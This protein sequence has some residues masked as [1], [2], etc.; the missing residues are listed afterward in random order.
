MLRRLLVDRAQAHSAGEDSDECGQ[1]IYVT[2]ALIG[3]LVR[4]AGTG[5]PVDEKQQRDEDLGLTQMCDYLN[6]PG[7]IN[8]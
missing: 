7:K 8:Q 6:V 4:K 3:G 5:E 1:H 2:G